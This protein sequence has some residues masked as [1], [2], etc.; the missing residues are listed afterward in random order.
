[1]LHIFTSYHIIISM[2]SLWILF[3]LHLKSFPVYKV[4]KSYNSCIYCIYCKIHWMIQNIQIL[5]SVLSIEA[6]FVRYR[7]LNVPCYCIFC[8]TSLLHLQL[9]TL[10]PMNISF[11]MKELYDIYTERHYI[12]FCK[13]KFNQSLVW[14]IKLNQTVMFM[15][16]P[17]M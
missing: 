11:L 14:P 1:M 9:T 7:R 12:F 17:I 5:N 3:H 13:I 16:C 8:S 15:L 10:I 2:S 4:Q 6:G